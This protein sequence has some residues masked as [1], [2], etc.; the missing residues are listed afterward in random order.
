[1]LVEP[2]PF[3]H[4]SGYSNRFNEMLRYLDKAGDSVEVVVPDNNAE[5]NAPTEAHGARVNT[6]PGFRFALYPLITLA[7]DLR[8]RALRAMK[9][10]RP[11]LL[12]VSSPGF[13]VFMGVAV[14]K[15]LDIPLVLSYHTHLPLYARAY[16]PGTRG[17]AEALSWRLIRLVHAFAD[18]T[19]VT[20][21]EMAA[22]FKKRGVPRVSVWRKGVD[23]ERFHPRFRSSAARARLSGGAPVDT[24]LVVYVGRLAAEKR[25]A[26]L[27]AILRRHPT[28]HLALVG[29]GP[30][31]ASLRR[32]FAES[33]AH[34]GGGDDGGGGEG[35]GGDRVHFAGCLSGNALSEAFASA[36][37]VAMPSDSETL[38]FVV[39]EAMASGVP[40]VGCDAGGIPSLLGREGTCGVLSAS[41]QR[42]GGEDLAAKVCGLL[43]PER[44]AER[45]AMGLAARREAER[46]DWESATAHL[47]NVQYSH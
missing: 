43:G 3:T 10:F 37:V 8:F 47:R 34:Q 19:L 11:E 38:G 33:L 5:G 18:L 31:E 29:A 12:H 41:G 6:I 27:A 15:L 44:V 32:Y 24:P 46:W 17:L 45:K 26:D 16:L 1:V 28:C 21:P 39:L 40:V 36:D 20:S 7:L 35:S 42:D 25:V 9:R 22:E 4:V 30:A 2:T 23:T 13:L 14:S